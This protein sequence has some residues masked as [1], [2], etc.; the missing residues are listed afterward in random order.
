MR[1]T[2]RAL[3]ERFYHEVWNRA[4]E[5]VARE[6]LH[7]D[8][9]F[10]ASLGPERRGADGFIDYMR[11]IHAALG[12]YT[13]TIEEIVTAEN[14]AAARMTFKG[15]HQGPFF[16]VEATGREIVWAGAA[17][18]TTDGQRI[19]ALWVLGDIDAVKRQLGAPAD[20]DFTSA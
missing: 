4:D 13:C 9:R 8:F 19:T 17:F 20:T 2:P 14:R 11:A 15:I 5:E 1:S 3:V 16:G 10:R 6:I 18:F 7:E 12:H